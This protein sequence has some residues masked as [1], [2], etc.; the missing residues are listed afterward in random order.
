MVF[1]AIA[2]GQRRL[3]QRVVEYGST[4]RCG[5]GRIVVRNVFVAET[6]HAGRCRGRQYGIGKARLRQG[7]RGAELPPSNQW[8]MVT[9]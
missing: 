9:R 4:G 2:S 1:R 3:K 5:R 7:N 6:L 8:E